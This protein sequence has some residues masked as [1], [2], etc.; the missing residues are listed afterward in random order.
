MASN[1]LLNFR[2]TNKA[3]FVGE[4]SNIVFDTVNSSLGIGTTGTGP[5]TSNLYITGNAYITSDI[6]VGGV[7]NMGTV[8]VVA[9]HDLEAVTALGNTTP[10]TVE[11]QNADTSLVST[12]NVE[13]GGELTVS[14]NVEVGTANLFVDTVSGRVGIGTTSPAKKLH[15]E[16]Y[17]SAIG[18]FEGIRIANHASLLHATVRPAYE[19]VV[20][21]ID[22]ATGIGNSKFAIGYR[23]TTS[24]SRTDR[25]VIDNS[26][27]VGI[28]TTDPSDTL[29]VY[30]SPIIQ[31]S[32]TDYTGTNDS[33]Y[34]VGTWD[35]TGPEVTQKGGTLHL[36]F[37]GG[38]LFG[39]NPAGKSEILAKV[40]NSSTYRSILWKVEGEKIFTDVRMRRVSNDAFKYDIC[41]KM[42]Y[43]TNHTM[44]TE[45]SRTTSFERKFTSTTEP[46][47][48]DTTNVELGIALPCTNAYG[49][50]GIGTTSPSYKLEVS[51]DV[52]VSGNVTAYSDRRAKSNIEKIQNPLDKIDK[53]SGYTYTMKV[54]DKDGEPEKEERFTGLIAQEVLEI[55]PEAVM[56]S[57]ENHYSLAYGNMAGLLV[58]AI[59][60]LSSELKTLKQKIS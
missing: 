59:K 18:D 60:E 5:P 48:T 40:G 27:N 25:L 8:N 46:S 52:H 6:S 11:F 33:W 15:V 24:A 42:K 43:Y 50:V 44:R 29:H 26:G 9:R 4:N 2:G 45:C 10:L 47:S 55:L 58:E 57:E 22:A 23:D 53:I 32:L 16:H 34:I 1:G 35:A 36:T 12:G 3:T 56:G 49:F 38:Q 19:F 54:K 30:G 39:S 37:L 7:L 41:V 51:G 20:S 28:G 31:H 17:G 21:D 13:V 14:G